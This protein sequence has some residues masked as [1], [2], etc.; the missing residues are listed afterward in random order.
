MTAFVVLSARAESSTVNGSVK[1]PA[2]RENCTS[3]ANPTPLL[4][5]GLPGVGFAKR[6]RN[7]GSPRT[8]PS[9]TFGDCTA[10]LN[11]ETTF[12][13]GFTSAR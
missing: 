8:R 9:D 13:A 10:G 3:G 7:A 2:G 6:P 1:F 12:V 4:A 11:S 5:F